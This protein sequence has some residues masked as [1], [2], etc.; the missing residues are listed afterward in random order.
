VGLLEKLGLR[1]VEVKQVELESTFFL[2]TATKPA[3]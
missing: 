2:V 1:D 3:V